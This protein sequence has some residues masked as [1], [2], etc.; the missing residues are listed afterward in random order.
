[1][2][3]IRTIGELKNLI[4]NLPND[5]PIAK[6]HCDIEKDGYLPVLRVRLEN[7]ILVEKE[8]QDACDY[9]PYTYKVFSLT[10]DDTGTLCFLIGQ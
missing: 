6:Y 1:M 9:T 4:K 8:T 10:H 2:M 3:I 7:A 5:M